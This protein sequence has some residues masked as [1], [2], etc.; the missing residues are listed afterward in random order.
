VA[1]QP[2]F[3]TNECWGAVPAGVSVTC[4]YVIVPENRSEPL[5]EENMIQ[6]AV[7]VLR[8]P[9][10]KYTQPPTFLLGGGP[11]QD[12]VGMYEGFFQDYQSLQEHGFPAEQYPGHLQDMQQFKAVMD[13]FVA[14]L[15]NREFVYFDQ[16][17]AGY[18]QPS[19]KCHGEDWGDCRSRLVSSGADIA[20]YNTLE[21]VADVNDVRLALG[22]EQINLQGG[23]YGTRLALE[24]LRQYPPIVR[25]TVLDGVVPPQIDWAVE[26]VR[27][28]D[29]ALQVLFDH[30]QADP[31]CKAA[32][33]DLDTVFY[34]LV[35][36]LNARPIE[37]Q[38]GD[39]VQTRNGDDLRDA[40]WNALYDANKIR[41][42]PMMI[43]Q[44][45]GGNP[46]VWGQ[47]LA[48]NTAGQG[49]PIAWGMHYSVECAE[50]WAFETPQDL[51]A[52]SEG[53]PLSIREAVVR[54]FADTFWICEQ[55][56]VPPASAIVH[57]PVQSDIPTL[58]LSGEFDPGTPPD[59]AEIVSQTL[60]HHYN[61]VLPYRGHTDGFTNLCQNSMTSAFLDNPFIEPDATC[62][63]QMD[64]PMFVMK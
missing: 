28:Y 43:A 11:G 18:S 22:Y 55:W 39:D 7:V 32:Y 30:C 27:R 20:A 46:A 6:L 12:V 23:S 59:F 37:V 62:I 8:A 15:Q 52:A 54:Y 29:D 40:I 13:L 53:L 45:N 57:T 64:K 1:Y 2:R 9:G 4:G 38:V 17:G 34:N 60:T 56:D 48:P 58:L 36:R 61:Y 5:T 47:M 26:M 16:R 50:R 24:V 51:F 19:L 14:D 33:P 63:A 3:E 42:L 31:T 44:V 21:N 10:V 25:A 35:E 49:E 41:F